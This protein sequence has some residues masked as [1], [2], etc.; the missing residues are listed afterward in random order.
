MAV[1]FC[2]EVCLELISFDEIF[3]QIATEPHNGAVQLH[4]APEQGHAVT[5]ELMEIESMS[6]LGA[7]DVGLCVESLT[8]ILELLHGAVVSAEGVAPPVDVLSTI[9]A[10]HAPGTA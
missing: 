2:N 7:T 5:G 10:R 1:D 4:Y 8:W 9:A 3:V 6:S